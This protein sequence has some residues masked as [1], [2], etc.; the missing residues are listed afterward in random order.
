M[1]SFLYRKFMKNFLPFKLVNSIIIAVSGGED[2][3]CLLRLLKNYFHTST[4]TLYAI[5][6]DHQW[7]KDS[8][9]NI[10]HLIN[11]T[12]NVG[13]HLTIYQIKKSYLNESETR[14]LRYQI[15]FRYA[16]VKK[17]SLILTGHHNHDK[18]ETILSNLV[19]GS[20]PYGL[21]Q[22]SLIKKIHPKI[23]IVRPLI[24]FSKLEISWLCR[25]LYLPVWSDTTNYNY[26]V[27]RNRIRH[28]LSPYL[29]NFV[30][31]KI[32]NCINNFFTLL[33]S[34][35]E[36]IQENVIKLYIQV[37]HPIFIGLNYKILAKQHYN[38][39]QKVLRLF[40]YYNYRHSLKC[41]LINTIARS[42]LSCY[43]KYIR[44]S[45]V[46]A[47]HIE[48]QQSWLYTTIVVKKATCATIK[49]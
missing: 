40:F 35:N 13:I 12:Q 21:N 6:I 19:R 15:L 38:L 49:I 43:R 4:S 2:S 24:N 10:K 5:Y 14:Q 31:P 48:L 3:L 41:N 47:L 7:R 18:L 17:C 28:E 23:Q 42:R 29:K 37:Q 32:E 34:D 44:I 20:S 36:Y 9:R 16:L 46:Y 27:K 22:F 11:V 25:L 33:H 39:K 26:Y 45:S 30:N 8:F 1:D